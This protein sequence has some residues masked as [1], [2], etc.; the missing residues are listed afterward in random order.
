MASAIHFNGNLNVL[1]GGRGTGKSTVVESLRYVL[2]LDPLGD[3]AR[4]AHEGII[5]HIESAVELKSRFYVRS[6]K[7]AK[8]EYMIGTNYTE[9]SCKY[10]IRMVTS[11]I[12]CRP[13]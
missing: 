6:H 1:I 4:K 2:A 5:R 3:D 11:S 7:P 10:A 8:S 12:Y 9:S 13:T